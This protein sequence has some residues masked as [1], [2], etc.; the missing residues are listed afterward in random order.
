MN[1]TGKNMRFI[2]KLLLILLAIFFP[3]MIFFIRDKPAAAVVALFLQC[4]FIGWPV[5]IV[6]AFKNLNPPSTNEQTK[7]NQN[8]S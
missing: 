1:T 8:E 2:G 7:E 5:A 6:W 3:F 4:T